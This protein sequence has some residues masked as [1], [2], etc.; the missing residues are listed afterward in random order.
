M[1]HW[2]FHLAK[3]HLDEKRALMLCEKLQSDDALGRLY[4]LTFNIDP[5]PVVVAPARPLGDTKNAVGRTFARY[6]AQ[7]LGFEINNKIFQDNAVRRD[8]IISPFVRL[9]HSPT[10]DG[11]VVEGANYLLADDIFTLGGT[12]ASLRGFIEGK[13]GFVIGMT[14]L[15]EKEGHD[16]KISLAKST[17]EALYEANNGKL[18]ALVP[19]RTGFPLECL[20]EPEG[21][22]LLQQSSAYAIRTG[23]DRAANG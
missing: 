13:G 2:C 1:G 14:A 9:A 3:Y 6:V 10:F 8:K 23:F 4:D 17:L 15:G 11:I 5:A 19:E 16:V 22:Y 18:A 12:L 7:E 20:T 21:R